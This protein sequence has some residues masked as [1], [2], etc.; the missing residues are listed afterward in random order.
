MV[1]LVILGAIMTEGIEVLGIAELYLKYGSAIYI[2]AFIFGVLIFASGIFASVAAYDIG[3]SPNYSNTNEDIREAYL[4]SLWASVISFVSLFIVMI[5][6]YFFH[7]YGKQALSLQKIIGSGKSTK[8]T[9]QVSQ[10]NKSSSNKQKVVTSMTS[11][12]EPLSTLSSQFSSGPTNITTSSASSTNTK[13]GYLSSA[14][15]FAANNP[16][17][18]NA[19]ISYLSG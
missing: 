19:A 13:S 1:F 2:F 4:F 6:I 9:S 3:N 16:E 15:N 10:V 17:L 18:T 7:F 12:G 8:S 14:I 11:D 5:G